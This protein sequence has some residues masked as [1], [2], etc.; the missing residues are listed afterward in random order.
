MVYRRQTL[1]GMENIIQ[2]S[3]VDLRKTYVAPTFKTS[4]TQTSDPIVV[5]GS[6]KTVFWYDDFSMPSCLALNYHV[7]PP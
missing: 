3:V 1:R 6:G 7:V 2:S 5:A 4:F